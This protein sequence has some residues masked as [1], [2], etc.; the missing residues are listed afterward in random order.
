MSLFLSLSRRTLL[1]PAW[2]VA[3]LMVP[4]TASAE[5]AALSWRTSAAPSSAGRRDTT[6]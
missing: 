5:P 1:L 2:C 3:A 4:M 6:A